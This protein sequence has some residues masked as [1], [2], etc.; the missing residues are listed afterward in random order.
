[1]KNFIKFLIFVGVLY[2]VDKS[3]SFK[4][5]LFEDSAKEEVAIAND[6]LAAALDEN[7][8]LANEATDLR[9]DLFSILLALNGITDDALTLERNRENDGYAD[10][11]SVAKQ[12]HARMDALRGQLADARRKAGKSEQLQQEIDRLEKSFIAK[13]Q[14]VKRLTNFIAKVDD[15]IEKTVKELEVET[16]KLKEK[17][18]ELKRVNE[19]RRAVF[20]E[21]TA[22][23]QQSWI[24]AGDELVRAARIIPRP[25]I[26]RQSNAIVDAK[27][28]LLR[29][30][31]EDCY[32]VAIRINPGTTLAADARY[33]SNDARSLYQR[34]SQRKD[35]GE[36]AVIYDAD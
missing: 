4:G 3:C 36:K 24:F 16:D 28:L 35:I 10:G 6:D 17:E 29:S 15:D 9:K 31:W 30:A 21:K 14:E 7:E 18:I 22:I 27:K 19:Q 2:F 8:H 33:L 5:L 32:D 13:K 11:Q 25:S 26:G 34:A 23:D 20:N 12:I 1:M